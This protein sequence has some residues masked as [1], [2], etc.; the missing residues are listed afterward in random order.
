M[1]A[2]D[3]VGGQVVGIAARQE[4]PCVGDPDSDVLGACGAS[5][6]K[7]VLVM[8]PMGV[9]ME[10]PPGQDEWTP[11]LI[12]WTACRTHI[13]AAKRFL[14]A[15]TPEEPITCSTE[16]L[17]SHW[18]QVVDPIDLPVFGLANMAAG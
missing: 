14:R 9:L 1:D 17:M 7:S 6:V 4:W 18:S 8:M 2:G 13:G 5:G 16:F 15:R 12:H 3:G 11:V 10:P